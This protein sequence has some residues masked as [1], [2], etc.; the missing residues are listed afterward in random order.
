VGDRR[1]DDA[2]PPR[3]GHAAERAE[4]DGLGLDQGARGAQGREG[5]GAEQGGER[6]ALS[7]KTGDALL[8][9]A[10]DLLL[11]HENARAVEQARDEDLVVVGRLQRVDVRASQ[12][13]ER[14]GLADVDAG[15]NDGRH[16]GHD[17]R[18]RR[19][20]DRHEPD[21]GTERVGH[22]SLL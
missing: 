2:Q 7:L 10:D 4:Q 6:G 11:A 12:P 16:V 15:A 19:L 17:V 8:D 18:A 13:V 3:P 9:Q 21:H 22:G 5:A 1:R 14:P 20:A